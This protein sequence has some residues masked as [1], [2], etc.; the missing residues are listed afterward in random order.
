[1]IQEGDF[2]FDVDHNGRCQ[3]VVFHGTKPI[4]SHTRSTRCGNQ[5]VIIF[6]GTFRLH[7]PKIHVNAPNALR[8]MKAAVRYSMKSFSSILTGFDEL[9]VKL[10]GDW[11][12]AEPGDDDPY[13]VCALFK[14][15]RHIPLPILMDWGAEG[16]EAGYALQRAAIRLAGMINRRSLRAARAACAAFE[17]ETE[18]E[19]QTAN[20]NR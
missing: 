17:E 10:N 20:A 11:V 16:C 14:N 6:P 9:Q 4:V 1:M 19:Q 15:G 12:S 18:L 8:A 5:W 13:Y 2:T 3:N 7:V